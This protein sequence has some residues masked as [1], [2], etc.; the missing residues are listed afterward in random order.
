VF[1]FITNE[2]RGWDKTPVNEKR[3]DSEGISFGSVLLVFLKEK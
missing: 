2:K 1:T 3:T